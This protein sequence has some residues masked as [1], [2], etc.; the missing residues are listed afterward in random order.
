[1]ILKCACTQAHTLSNKEGKRLVEVIALQ[2]KVVGGNHRHGQ[3]LSN[4]EIIVL[5]SLY[6]HI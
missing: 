5:S 4:V 1:M 2:G 3:L 6:R